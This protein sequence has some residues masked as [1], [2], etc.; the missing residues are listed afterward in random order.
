[1]KA[2]WLRTI[3]ISAM[4]MAAVVPVV[5]A[6]PPP[7]VEQDP[8]FGSAVDDAAHPLGTAQREAKALAVEAKSMVV[9]LPNATAA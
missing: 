6:A 3:L 9:G 5:M 7:P 2:K 8:Q 4:L 1:M